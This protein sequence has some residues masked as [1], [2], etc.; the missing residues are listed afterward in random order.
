MARML[1]KALGGMLT[2]KEG[3]EL[4]SAFD[5][6]GGIIVVRIPDSLLHKR[7]AIGE[8]LLDQVKKAESVFYQSSNVDGDHRTRS[9]ELLAGA[10]STETEYRENGCR[11]VVDVEKAFFSPR[12]STE[13]LRIAGLVSDADV[14]INM[15]AGIGTFSIIAA[16]NAGCTVYSI[17]INPVASDL[18][19]RSIGMNKLAGKVVSINGDAAEVIRDRLADTGTRTLMLLPERSD[20]FLD[21]A[22]MATKDGGVIHY[23]AHTRAERR[24]G[25]PAAAEAH[26]ASVCPVKHS[27]LDSR[28]VRAVGPRYHQTVVDARIS[29]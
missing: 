16:K 20:E 25:A 21:S 15:F 18:C 26:F 4:F 5:Q 2:P 10:D 14:I 27:I 19:R 3:S 24:T 9:L 22:V 17:D 23:Y 12:L 6:I 11:F 29:R 28:N 1:K 7:R 13:R 8:V